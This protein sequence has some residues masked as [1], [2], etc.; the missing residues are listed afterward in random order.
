MDSKRKPKKK[1]PEEE[2]AL[3]K[4]FGADLAAERRAQDKTQLD[5]AIP[6]NSHPQYIS[7]LE[8]EGMEPGLIK[9]L[10]LAAALEKKPEDLLKNVWPAF[11][12]Y[13]KRMQK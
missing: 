9:L 13:Y 1:L 8:N 4:L 10:Y 12:K 5:I 3:L 7:Q 11:L 6:M 2:I